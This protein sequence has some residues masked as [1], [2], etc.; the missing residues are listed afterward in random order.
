MNQIPLKNNSE[1]DE[2]NMTLIA[3]LHELRA[4]LTR[5]A[6]GIFIAV[7]LCWGFSEYIFNFVRE[8]AV[9]YLPGGGL[10]FTAPMDKFLAHLNLSMV[11]G[12]IISSP[13]WLFQLW[14]FISPALYRNERK[15][16]VGFVGAGTFQFLLGVAFCYYIVLPGAI[17]FLFNF[18]GDLDK[19][20][21]TIKDYI[22]F[23]TQMAVMFGLTFEI[24]VVLTFLGF[25]GV[26]TQ[27]F[28]IEKRRYSIVIN[29]V[30]AAI[31]APPDTYSMILL[32]IP[33]MVMY[34]ISIISVGI[35]EKK[36]LVENNP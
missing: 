26:L 25:L 1:Q 30:I 31:A 15:L 11:A 7:C 9:K 32:M 4:R 2:G 3:H 13:F 21:I 35:F 34:E 8:P 18:G 14:K 28:L 24:P 22:S 27:K 29:A 33:L 6:F 10:V 36:N 12:L 19:P 20:M 17:E 16:V 23:F 5:S